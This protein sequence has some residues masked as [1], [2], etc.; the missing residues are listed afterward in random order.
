M[1]SLVKVTKRLKIEDKIK[2]DLVI[3]NLK[4]EVSTRYFVDLLLKWKRM[5]VDNGVKEPLKSIQDKVHD[6]KDI[7]F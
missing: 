6:I 4:L 7:S 1:V 3:K 2:I 5:L